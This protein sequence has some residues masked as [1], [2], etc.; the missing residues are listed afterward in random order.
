MVYITK[1]SCHLVNVSNL[2]YCLAYAV[3]SYIN[4]FYVWCFVWK[5]KMGV[6]W[7]NTCQNVQILSPETK[8]FEDHYIKGKFY[9]TSSFP[10][11]IVFSWECWTRITCN[12]ILPPQAVVKLVSMQN[13]FVIWHNNQ[14]IKS[15]LFSIETGAV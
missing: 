13:F 5:K 12:M 1:C 6:S 4:T 2:A 3:H 15:F 7:A 14:R 9:L 10:Q 11:I 8:P